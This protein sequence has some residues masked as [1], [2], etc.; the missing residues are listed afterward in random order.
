VFGFNPEL[1]GRDN[2]FLNGAILGFSQKEVTAMYD[3]IVS[4]AELEQHMDQK[5][6][7]YSS[8][9]QVR[10][11]F[12]M[13]VRA[14]ADILLIDEVLAVGDADFQRKCFDYFKKLKKEKTTVIFVSHNMDAIREYCDRAMLIEDTRVVG[15][16]ST[17][18][19]A[20]KYLRMFTEHESSSQL[21]ASD[22]RWGDH[23][24]KITDISVT[25]SDTTI[26]IHETLKTM[27][28]VENPIIGFRIRDAAGKDVTG[29][30]NKVEQKT[31]GSFT[32]GQI[33]KITW[34]IPNL[35]SDGEYFVDPAVLHDDGITA[36]D[37]WNEATKIIIKKNRHL[38]YIIDP[39]FELK[40][41]VSK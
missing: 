23:I 35:L 33:I 16:G 10:L 19:I 6:K 14:K 24:V 22:Q 27:Q 31:L 40:V 36:Y 3:D 8:G 17:S 13:A 12:S 41:D 4:F 11:A 18:T 39:G 28:A 2:V 32:K 7:N 26:A 9:M 38:P 30:N 20:E 5:L 37:W 21:T 34:Q 25:T 15:I 1:T 29:T